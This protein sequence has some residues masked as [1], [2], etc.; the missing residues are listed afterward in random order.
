MIDTDVER[1]TFWP[2]GLRMQLRLKITFSEWME[3][4]II[5]QWHK[6]SIE[7]TRQESEFVQQVKEKLGIV[8][9]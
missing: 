2:V 1:G 7:A 3:H 5:G 9:E 6:K 8:S 4:T